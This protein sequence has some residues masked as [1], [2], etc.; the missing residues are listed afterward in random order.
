ML[1]SYFHNQ[2]WPVIRASGH[3]FDLPQRKHSIDN[4]AKDH[5]FSVQEITIGCRYEELLKLV[6]S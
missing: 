6:R 1:T 2:F 4:F 3:I 5:M